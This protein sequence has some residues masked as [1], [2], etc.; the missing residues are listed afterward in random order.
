MDKIQKPKTY[1]LEDRTLEFARE[2]RYFVKK[3]PRTLCNKED[4]SQLVRAS[5]SV[6]A[7][8]IEANEAISKKD[9]THR[10]KISRKE[11][12][13]SRFWLRLVDTEKTESLDIQRE[14]LIEEAVELMK[15][16]SS[17]MRKTE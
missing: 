12:K 8:Y 17:I 2:C 9:F 3:L 6:G 1:D 15:I 11:A 14:K 4:G 10:I 16:F 7:N 5:G 13:E